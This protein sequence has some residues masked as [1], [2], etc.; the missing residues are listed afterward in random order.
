M[1]GEYIAVIFVVIMH[2]LAGKFPA[3]MGN[4]NGLILR[5]E[6]AALAEA[7]KNWRPYDDSSPDYAE[8]GGGFFLTL[9]VMTGGV[10]LSKL[11]P[12]IMYV[13]WAII[14]C[15]VVKC[16]GLFSDQVCR[17]AHYWSQFAIK[18]IVVVLV[19]ALGMTSGASAAIGSVFNIAT[20]AVI[21][22]TFL[23]A[24]IGAMIACVI[25]GLYR[26]EG[27]LT[28]A[29]CACNI[30]ASGDLQMLIIANRLDLLAFATISTRIGG[31]LMLLE[32][33]LIFPV[34]ARALGKM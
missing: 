29:M 34:V 10:L 33:S 19:T 12:Q 4:G 27:A 18:N 15:I 7:Q 21:V 16:S 14:I 11:V 1:I 2:L 8:L 3:L 25:F 32:I 13:A 22:L 23:G 9:A 26:Y 30:G 24:I 17:V 20:V 31:G 6:S 28:A 5:K